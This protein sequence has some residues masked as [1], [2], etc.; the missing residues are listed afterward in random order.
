MSDTGW[1]Y[2]ANSN[3]LTLTNATIENGH[4]ISSE[5]AGI[6]YN[7]SGTLNIVLEG[8]NSIALTSGSLSYGIYYPNGS[9]VIS[10]DGSLSTAENYEG[11][12]AKSITIEG[13]T[14]NASGTTAG[15]NTSGEDI[16]ISGGTVKA[17]ATGSN[18]MLYIPQGM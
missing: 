6:F 3:T 7:G 5:S 2:D 16:K 18:G 12:N 17:S 15:L 1:N 11:I 9:V 13:G 4:S 8:T 14:I 10:G